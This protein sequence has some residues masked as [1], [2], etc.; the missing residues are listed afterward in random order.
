MK[1]R[2]LKILL[3]ASVCTLTAC[4]VAGC[5]KNN[6]SNSSSSKKESETSITAASATSG[7]EASAAG[8]NE[9]GV[10]EYSEEEI[11]PEESDQ[12]PEESTEESAKESTEESTKESTEESTDES[13]QEST[14]ESSEESAE[15]NST[16]S[17]ESVMTESEAA[18][19][20]IDGYQFDDEQIVKDY[21]TATEFTSDEEFNKI[22]SGNALD[23]QYQQDLMSAQS[24]SSMRQT[25]IAYAE[26]WKDLSAQAYDALY[27]KLNDR[28]EEQQKLEQSQ[29]EW[30]QSVA[31]AESSFNAEASGGGTEAFLSADAAMM[32]YYKG[33]AAVLFDQIYV[34]DGSIDLSAYGL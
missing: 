21:H 4:V 12:Q 29:N 1:L 13:T 34:L 8:E 10:P 22:F 3:A 31:E 20:V 14:E 25:T 15:E 33:R 24:V 27:A 19:V 23:A 32:N 16:S 11:K 6:D 17:E 5:T 18:E 30:Q 26:K 2:L 9:Q 7:S 28:P